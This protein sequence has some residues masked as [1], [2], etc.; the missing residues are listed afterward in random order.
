MVDGAAKERECIFLQQHQHRCPQAYGNR[1]GLGSRTSLTRTNSMVVKKRR[2]RRWWLD[3][4]RRRCSLVRAQRQPHPQ[5]CRRRCS[6]EQQG[7]AIRS[8]IFPPC[9]S[10]SAAHSRSRQWCGGTGRRGDGVKPNSPAAWR[11]CRLA[12]WWPDSPNSAVAWRLYGLPPLPRTRAHGNGAA[13]LVGGGCLA[14]CAKGVA[15]PDAKPEATMRRHGRPSGSPMAT[16]FPTRTT[17]GAAMELV[18]DG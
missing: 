1:R 5:E 14:C 12:V 17:G 16:R 4:E 3:H 18:G 10:S 9:T 8:K 13:A 2:H 11:R 15:D 7:D 6:D